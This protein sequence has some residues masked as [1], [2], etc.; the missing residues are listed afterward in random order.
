MLLRIFTVNELDV[1]TDGF[2]ASRFI[3]SG[4]CGRVYRG[5]LASGETVAVKRW[6]GG[7]SQ[8]GDSLM[9]LMNELHTLGHIAHR[10]LLPVL[11]FV[12]QPPDIMLVTP[13][14]ARGSLHDALHGA[15]SAAA[16]LDAAWRVSFLLDMAR[17]VQS[18]HAANIVH[19]D[20]RSANV[21]IGDDGRAVLADAG[22]ARRL[23]AD[24]A[25]A[26]AATG[27][28]VIGTDGYLD[29]EYQHTSTL[30]YKSDVFSIGVVILEM[31]TGK[32]A[33]DPSAVP[34]LLWRRFHSI[35]RADDLDQRVRWLVTEAAQCW[36]SGAAGA[37]VTATIALLASL[38]LQATAELSASRPSVDVVIASLEETQRKGGEGEDAEDVRICMVCFAK[39]RAVR[40]D[41][42][43][44][45]TCEDCI[46]SWPGCLVCNHS[47]GVDRNL[48]A[49]P[50]DLTYIASPPVG[51][52]PPGPND[53]PAP[54]A[55]LDEL[56]V[57]LAELRLGAFE[58]KLRDFGVAT[59]DD[60]PDVEDAE[61]GEMGVKLVKVRQLRRAV[62]AMVGGGGEE[63]LA[64][65]LREL[66]LVDFAA[67]LRDL[68]VATPGDLA[69][70]EDAELAEMGVKPFKMRHLRRVLCAVAG[71]G[72]EDS[73]NELITFLAELRMAEC[74][75]TLIIFGIATLDDLAEVED[76]ELAEMGIRPLKLRQLRRA[77]IHP[78]ETILRLWR[79]QCPAL[80]RLWPANTDVSTWKGVVFAKTDAADTS[81]WSQRVV[82]INV[83]GQ[84][85]DATEVPAALGGLGALRELNLSRNQLTCVPTAL[86]A[87]TALSELQLP[88]NR[89]TSV[90]AELGNL[91]ALKLLDL[92]GNNLTS[93][94]AALGKLPALT[95]LYLY[96]NQMSLDGK[97]LTSLPVEIRNIATLL[98]ILFQI[99]PDK[100]LNFPC[101]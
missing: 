19:R 57:L 28:R 65:F 78:D 74:A 33:R 37:G 81:R 59:P 29:P 85:G 49:N 66:R 35:S 75:V 7:T 50:R 18:L 90:P 44:M 73:A 96:G 68:G 79:D 27:T 55:E 16:G 83:E 30:T 69:D 4:G 12:C 77:L 41:C 84:L 43:H 86:G 82:T 15:G 6:S 97:D 25:A 95:Q 34:P 11:G 67:K 31:L 60:L 40:F 89:L 93:V 70:V 39:P 63:A 91:T 13:H 9:E 88:G 10:N 23:I 56:S 36:S 51:N 47:T 94:P 87:L 5:V 14:M 45:T 99:T 2:A 24:A 46:A 3:G 42:G 62:C 64:P 38:A 98:P 101:E 76:A 92:N 58:T 61:L 21:L 48:E 22:V 8:P 26:A 100:E 80:Q 71:G 1:A 17:G 32:P 72:G 20:V 52:D 53:V 54:A